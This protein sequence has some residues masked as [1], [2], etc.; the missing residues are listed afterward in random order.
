MLNL[1]NYIVCSGDM[2]GPSNWCNIGWYKV[3][4]SESCKD[5][6]SYLWGVRTYHHY[7]GKLSWLYFSQSYCYMQ[8]ARL[9]SLQL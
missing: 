4:C 5:C 8:Y 3:S 9:L 6:Q 2:P 1:I 7:L